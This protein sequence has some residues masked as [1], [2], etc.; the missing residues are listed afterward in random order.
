MTTLADFSVTDNLTDVLAVYYNKLLGSILRGEFS[1]PVTM[2]TD[3]TLTD[4]DTPIQRLNCNGANRVVK[5]P[6]SASGNHLF[7]IINTSGGAYTLTVKSYDAVTTI[8]T[9]AQGE[10]VLVVPNGTGGYVSIGAQVDLGALIHAA[11]SKPTPVDADELALWDSAV[12]ALKKLTW[13]NLKTALASVFDW[14]TVTHAATSKSM[15]VDAD[16]LSIV[17]SAA[18]NGIKRLTWANLKAA[19]TSVLAAAN[20]WISSSATWSYSSLDSAAYTGVINV[21][22]D[23]TGLIGKGDRIS[24]VQ[25][26][27]QKWGIVTNVGTYLGGTTPI[28]F[29]YGTN[30]ALAN[31]TITSP[32]FSHVKNPFGFPSEQ[33][34]WTITITDTTNLVQASPVAGTYYNLGS[35]SMAVP[36]GV[37]SLS[38]QGVAWDDVTNA[39]CSM[40]LALSTSNNSLSDATFQDYFIGYGTSVVAN[41]LKKTKTINLVSKT[42]YYLIVMTGSSGVANIRIRGDV[43]TTEIRAV[44]AYL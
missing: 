25:S 21:A 23:M 24:Y 13:A 9:L 5:V 19:L 29:F 28:T 7:L 18:G 27:T 32:M 43:V 35:L 33:A 30:T 10:N 38:F 36:I 4:G 44:C 42:T 12:S 37:W 17:D 20:G 22:A 40:V 11:T 26:S 3:L 15:P 6:A 14:A 16:E 8:T 2:T 34:K 41:N 31:A 39:Q 1:N